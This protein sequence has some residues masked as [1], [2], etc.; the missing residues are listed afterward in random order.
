MAA[1]AAT[2][3]SALTNI[4]LRVATVLMQL[5]LRTPSR[6]NN[7][8]QQDANCRFSTAARQRLILVIC[9]SAYAGDALDVIATSQGSEISGKR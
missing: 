1:I 2:W 5:R 8:C 9:C 3:L 7:R 4:K 6:P